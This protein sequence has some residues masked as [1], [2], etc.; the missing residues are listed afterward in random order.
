MIQDEHRAIF[1]AIREGEANAARAAMRSHLGN[2][3]ERYRRLAAGAD[4]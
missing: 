3:C 2:S 1:A 4:G